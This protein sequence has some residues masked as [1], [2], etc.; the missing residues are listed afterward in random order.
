MVPKMALFWG[1]GGVDIWFCVRDSE[2]A[3]PNTFLVRKVTHA[4]K[5]YAWAD[6]DELLH[7]CRSARR[8]HLC[9]LLWLSLMW[10]ERGGGSNFGFLH[11]L[12]L[13]PLQHSRT[14]VR[15]CDYLHHF[16]CFKCTIAV[17]MCLN[18][19]VFSIYSLVRKDEDNHRKM[20]LQSFKG[21]PKCFTDTCEP[22]KQLKKMSQPWRK[23]TES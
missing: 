14:T 5:R 17:N 3:H 16:C 7:S 2:K 18:F 13:S 10:F 12:A 9:Q 8:N 22:F 4:Q 15:V 19:Q 21:K 23:T 11:W 6:C 20:M 1:N